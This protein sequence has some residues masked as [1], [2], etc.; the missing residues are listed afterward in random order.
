MSRSNV[1]RASRLMGWVDIT[2]R[3]GAYGAVSDAASE[4]NPKKG[5]Y[6]QYDPR[7]EPVRAMIQGIYETKLEEATGKSFYNKQ[8]RR[9]EAN[10]QL[11]RYPDLLQRI[12]TT[13]FRIGRGNA[14]KPSFGYLKEG[15]PT[16][17]CISEAHERYRNYDHLIDNRQAYE[18]TLGMT[19]KEG[20][21]RVVQEFVG[22]KTKFFVWPLRP[23]HYIPEGFST[24]EEAVAKAQQFNAT[25]DPRMTGRWWRMPEQKYT[26]KD[27]KGWLP[28]DSVFSANFGS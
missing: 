28:A 18:E 6:E 24:Y 22:E 7:E 12:K 3:S 2:R 5:K 21:Y 15:K 1:S 16:A 11:Y 14:A 23:G 13:A 20:F 26:K 8:A 4:S 17:R 9:L 25:A 10:E 27:L 19:R